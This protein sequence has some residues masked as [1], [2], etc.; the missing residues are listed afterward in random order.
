[1]GRFHHPDRDPQAGNSVILSI[2][3]LTSLATLSGLTVITTRG[4]MSAE[5]ND[6]FHTIATRAAESGAASAM[7]Y[8]RAQIPTG[9]TAFVSANNANPVTLT[10]PANGVGP[11]G[12]NNQFHSDQQAYYNVIVLNNRTD[13]GFTTGTD[14]DLDLI[15]QSTGYGPNGAVSVI[16]WEVKGVA[17]GQ[18]LTLIGWREIL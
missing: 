14:T 18:P 5:T 16:E 11:G 7:D 9:W 12:T 1:V 10:F 3:I 6:R 2:I 4:T 8:L 17:V 15:I 13:P